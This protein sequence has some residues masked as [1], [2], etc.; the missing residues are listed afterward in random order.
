MRNVSWAHFTKES[1]RFP[2]NGFKVYSG[3]KA[4]VIRISH[5][6]MER[7]GCE[8]FSGKSHL[9]RTVNVTSLAVCKQSHLCGS[10]L[11]L[12]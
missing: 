4:T 12:E 3:F 2:G 7:K 1:D 10:D 5:S 8:A 9:K 11:Q 6:Y